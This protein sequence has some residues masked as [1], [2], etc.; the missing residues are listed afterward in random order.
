MTIAE[1]WGAW[2]ALLWRRHAASPRLTEGQHHRRVVARLRILRGARSTTQAVT[3][4]RSASLTRMWSMRSPRF[5]WNPACGSPTTNS[6]SR[7]VRTV[8]RHP[9]APRPS[10]AWKWR[11]PRGCGG[12]CLP[13]HRVI[14][15]AVFGRDIEIAQHHEARMGCQLGT[16]PVVQCGQPSQLVRQTCPSRGP[17]H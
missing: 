2:V 13:A 14:G 7:A 17:G 15:V 8:D 9:S 3:V 10:R 6:S 12:W 1:G 11:A 16:H 4:A 5:F